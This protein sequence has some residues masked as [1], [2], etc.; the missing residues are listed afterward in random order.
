MTRGHRIGL[1]AASMAV[2]GI[3]YGFERISINVSPDI[4]VLMFSCL[5]MLS[6]VSLFLEHYFTKPTDVLANTIAILLILAPLQEQLSQLG[7]WYT[8]FFSFNFI[9][10]LASLLALVLLD[11][12]KSAGSIQNVISGHLKRFSVHFGNGRFLWFAFLLLVL[13]GYVSSQDWEFATAIVYGLAIL[14]IDPHGYLIG[15]VTKQ[16]SHERDIGEIFGVQSKN[17]FLAKL[18]AQRISVRRFDLAEFRYV[19]G[20]MQHVFKGLII[21]NYLLNEEQW[22]KILCAEEIR[23]ELGDAPSNQIVENNVVYK[24]PDETQVNLLERLV[25]VIVENSSIGKIRF[26]FASK[27]AVSEGDFVEVNVSG[28]RVLYQVVQGVTQVELLASKNEAGYVVGEAVQI[29]IWNPESRSFEKYGWVPEVNSPVFLPTTVDDIPPEVGEVRIGNIP[30]TNFPMIINL[31]Q[32]ITHHLAILGVTG[33]GKSVFARDLIRKLVDAGI[34][35]ICVDFTNEYRNKFADLA[36]RSIVTDAET[37]KIFPAVD[38]III[39]RGKFSNQQDRV[40]IRG[41]EKSI[42]DTFHEALKRFLESESGITLFELPDV[43]NSVGILSYTRWF[44]RVLFD[45]AKREANFG[46]R[47]CIVL[48][49]AHTV[50]PEWNFVGESDTSARSLVNG[51]GQIALQGRKYKV[52]FVVI[53][54]RTANVSKT[55]LTQC[56]SIIAFQQFDRTSSDFLSNYMGDDMVNV[57]PRL[58][59]RHAIAVGKGYK[60]GIPIIFRVPE[61]RE[62]SA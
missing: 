27:V 8:I 22:I 28:R 25:G 16:S 51:I 30:N 12:D 59:P 15:L 7:I 2:L 23:E 19:I 46:Q 43:E 53:A 37:E 1:F 32:A 26:E 6:F 39:E 47:I 35:V 56:N 14:A 4:S 17:T 52:G 55:V 24:L 34:K 49:E 48:E 13:F 38:A 62:P 36:I 42:H 58:K 9:L 11:G 44:F 61:I 5:I 21:D 40:K 10:L 29:G 3:V 60:G 50:I 54:Q 45:I 57:L 33:T 31:E 20:D 41:W 18:Y